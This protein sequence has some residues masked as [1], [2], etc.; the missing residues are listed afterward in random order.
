[1]IIDLTHIKLFVKGSLF[2]QTLF[3]DNF[4]DEINLNEAKEQELILLLNSA[5]DN[6][7]NNYIKRSAFVI[8]CELTLI[9]KNSNE[10][11]VLKIIKDFLSSRE[12]SLIIVAL[13][14]IPYFFK[15]ITD[16]TIDRI[17]QLSDSFDG[18][19]ASQSYFCLGLIELNKDAL[20][21][22]IDNLIQSLFKP[23]QYFSEAVSC[24]ENREDAKFYLLLIDWIELIMSD[25]S[26]VLLHKK[27]QEIE[28]NLQ[29]RILYNFSSS[30]LEIDF[31]IFLLLEK[32]K[33]KYNITSQANKWIDIRDNVQ[34]LL[35]VKLELQKI[36]N[37]SLSHQSLV[38]PLYSNIIENIK[39]YLYNT[40]LFPEKERLKVLEG[41]LE[42]SKLKE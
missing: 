29:N 14:F 6:G 33:L 39:Q 3:L 32:L 37:F 31:I 17:K 24:S 26:S 5:I 15:S 12:S 27:F 34:K 28:K 11:V 36:K 22:N 10:Y 18:D 1:M 40:Y 20:K 16:Q 21:T 9:K 42:V 7:S 38:E 30:S 35:D 19:I 25:S 41:K 4:Y 23:K 13:K 2:K 8:L